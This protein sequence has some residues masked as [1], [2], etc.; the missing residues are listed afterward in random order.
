[1]TRD[2]ERSVDAAIEEAWN[3]IRRRVCRTGMAAAWHLGK[4]RAMLGDPALLERHVL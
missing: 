2:E 4:A 1:M 3:R